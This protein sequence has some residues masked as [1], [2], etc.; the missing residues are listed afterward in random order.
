MFIVFSLKKQDSTEETYNIHFPKYSKN[1]YFQ[2]HISLSSM[3]SIASR[4]LWNKIIRVR[5]N[6]QETNSFLPWSHI[7]I[8]TTSGN[9]YVLYFGTHELFENIYF[10]VVWQ[11]RVM[12]RNLLK[13]RYLLSVRQSI[14]E[15]FGLKWTS[16]KKKKIQTAAK[17][18]YIYIYCLLVLWSQTSSSMY[19]AVN[20]RQ[21]RLIKSLE[22]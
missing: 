9:R 17:E 13:V 15:E 7:H 14:P 16:K 19:Q 18:T 3:K 12:S 10:W 22:N 11:R 4:D 5:W 20:F 8:W 21:Q 1:C 6:W 2:K